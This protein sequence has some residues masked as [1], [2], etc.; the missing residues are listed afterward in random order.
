MYKKMS[1]ELWRNDTDRR[2]LKYSDKSCLGASVHKK[3]H[4]EWRGID[5]TPPPLEVSD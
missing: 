3:S 1:R 2:R 5:P 4:M